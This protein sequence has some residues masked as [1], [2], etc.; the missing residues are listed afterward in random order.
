M[1]AT[2]NQKQTM[3][4]PTISTEDGMYNRVVL[5]VC[6][7]L[8]IKCNIQPQKLKNVWVIGYIFVWIIC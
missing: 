7:R 8:Y 3:S 2:Q 1:S 6:Q 4:L 5:R